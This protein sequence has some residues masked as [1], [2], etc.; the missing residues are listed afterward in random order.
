MARKKNKRK[1]Q[2]PD[3]ESPALSPRTIAEMAGVH[4]VLLVGMLWGDV[5]YVWMQ[6]LLAIELIV[7]SLATVVL[8]PGRGVVKHVWDMVKLS[9][10]LAF[11][12]YLIVVTYGNARGG[13]GGAFEAGVQA[14][15]KLDASTLGWL[16]A[17]TIVHVGIALA[18]A[19][20]SPNPKL[21]WTKSTLTGG[22]V[23]VFAMILMIVVAGFLGESLRTHLASSRIPLVVDEALGALMV[24]ARFAFSLIVATLSKADLDDIAANP[25]MT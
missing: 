13:P 2:K 18:Q 6:A 7:L 1:Q 17:Y 5:P 25:Y 20:R 19:L 11:L 21:A 9:G 24:L 4:A 16:I 10:T 14:S 23:T 12:V 8:Y 15:Q 22:T 3:D